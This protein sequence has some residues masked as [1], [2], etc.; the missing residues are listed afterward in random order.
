MTQLPMGDELCGR[1]SCK[2]MML[3][4]T[5]H[6]RDV[7]H[8]C[9]GERP[10]RWFAQG[11]LGVIFQ[12]SREGR[13]GDFGRGPAQTRLRASQGPGSRACVTEQTVYGDPGEIYSFGTAYR[14]SL[15]GFLL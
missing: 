11:V 1:C 14:A 8:F 4:R 5:E 7:W 6:K 3:T 12:G 13:G 9:N 15:A 10:R 2:E